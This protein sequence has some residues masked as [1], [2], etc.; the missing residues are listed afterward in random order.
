[1]FHPFDSL[2]LQELL[3]A[4]SNL[5]TVIIY[6]NPVH[7]DVI[8]EFGYRMIYQKTGWNLCMWTTIFV[9]ENLAKGQ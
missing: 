8:R 2:A 1:M 4:L 9:S 5:K 3:K 6:N 7:E